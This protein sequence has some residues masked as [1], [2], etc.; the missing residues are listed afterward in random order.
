MCQKEITLQLKYISLNKKSCI[1]LLLL[2]SEISLYH[3]YILFLPSFKV[4]LLFYTNFTN[5]NVTTVAAQLSFYKGGKLFFV[6]VLS[7]QLYGLLG[8]SKC[9]AGLG[10]HKH[11]LYVLMIALPR[12]KISDHWSQVQCP[13]PSR[14]KLL[15]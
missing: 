9:A 13:P 1:F 11:I 5:S 7:E 12:Y 14:V 15:K 10:W 4:F 2:N 6:E 8:S 3:F